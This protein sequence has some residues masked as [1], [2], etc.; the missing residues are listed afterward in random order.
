MTVWN[1]AMYYFTIAP[2][3]YRKVFF[4][5]RDYSQKRQETVAEYYMRTYAHLIPKVVE[6]WEYDE[7]KKSANRLIIE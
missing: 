5:L 2:S 6:I 7:D 4:V 3:G 1:E